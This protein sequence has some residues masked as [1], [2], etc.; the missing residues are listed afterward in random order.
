MTDTLPPEV[1]RTALRQLLHQQRQMLALTIDV[2]NY[3]WRSDLQAEAR[4]YRARIS[5][6]EEE[7]DERGGGCVMALKLVGASG[8]WPRD[9]H[10]HFVETTQPG[11]VRVPRNL[12]ERAIRAIA[13]AHG[14]EITMHDKGDP[15]SGGA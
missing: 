12:A 6:L 13:A 9:F 11:G 1:M 5:W 14:I 8:E 3:Q 2:P 7:I 10:L 4:A 15:T